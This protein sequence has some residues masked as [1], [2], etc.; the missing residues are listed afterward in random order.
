MMDISGEVRACAQRAHK[1]YESQLQ[2]MRER[3]TDRPDDL[4]GDRFAEFYAARELYGRYA[5]PL[6]L[7]A[8]GNSDFN[9]EKLLDRIRDA[10]QSALRWLLL[11]KLDNPGIHG[12]TQ[13]IAENA[14]RQFLSDTDFVGLEDDA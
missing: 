1:Q 10:R 5:K 6:A 7:N 8:V 9:N 11:S 13:R 12:V 3:L 14:A 2:A 4:T